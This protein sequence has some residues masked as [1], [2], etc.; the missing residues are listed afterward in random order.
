MLQA[1]A[2]VFHTNIDFVAA[3][4][5]LIVVSAT[6]GAMAIPL[7]FGSALHG[8]KTTRTKIASL[9][10][11]KTVGREKKIKITCNYRSVLPSG[12]K[13]QYVPR[14]V[15]N[16]SA[17]SFKT[18]EESYLRIELTFTN[19]SRARI[20]DTRAIYLAIDDDAGHNYLRREL[21]RVDF[22]RLDPGKALTVSDQ[23]LAGALAPG[24]YV[25]H[26]WIPSPEP[27]LKFDPAGNLLL[28][29]AGVPDPTTGLNTLAEF[30]VDQ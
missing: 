26:L 29:S 11:C 28:S 27:S 3:A 9:Q 12:P 21:R 25:V 18:N 6:L 16:R 14:I 24:H 2:P 13:E 5:R 7:I 8:Q 23:L 19:E 4:A 17:L 10:A 1:P 22:R 30:Q 20:R 15:L